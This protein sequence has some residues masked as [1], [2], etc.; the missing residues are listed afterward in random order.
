MLGSETQVLPDTL[1]RDFHPDSRFLPKDTF[2]KR[3]PYL[4]WKAGEHLKRHVRSIHT[5]EKREILS[6]FFDPH[7]LTRAYS[8]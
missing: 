8:P 7:I 6:L 3:G 4:T 1:F 5:H 2:G